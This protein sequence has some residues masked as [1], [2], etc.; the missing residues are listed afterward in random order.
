MHKNA[1]NNLLAMVAYMTARI[2]VAR[3]EAHDRGATATEYALLVA[4]IAIAIVVAVTAFGKA[5]A[6]FFNRLTAKVGTWAP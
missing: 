3:D 6:T 2:N 5:L 4:F 1:I